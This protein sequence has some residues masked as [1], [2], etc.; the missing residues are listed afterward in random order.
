MT[1]AKGDIMIISYNDYVG[2]G[3]N[4]SDALVKFPHILDTGD[5]PFRE[6]MGEVWEK[7]LTKNHV[8]GKF[9]DNYRKKSN[10]E[11]ADCL[12]LDC[13][14]DSDNEAEWIT[15][16]MLLDNPLL[17]DCAL[18]TS[19]SRNHMKV[20]HAGTDKEKSAR[21]RFHVGLPLSRC[22]VET[23]LK[24]IKK[25]LLYTDQNEKQVRAETA[26]FDKGAK[27]TAHLIYGVPDTEVKTKDGEYVDVVMC[28][29]GLLCLNGKT[30][31]Y[32]AVLSDISYN[33]PS[34]P[35]SPMVSADMTKQ[36]NMPATTSNKASGGDK[37]E[38]HK[39][40]V[41]E[42][43]DMFK[44]IAKVDNLD[45]NDWLHMAMALKSESYDFSLFNELS[46]MI[47]CYVSEEDCRVKWDSVADKPVDD[48][49]T[50]G[51]LVALAQ[52]GGY[53]TWE[54][55]N[56]TD[57]YAIAPLGKDFPP[58][59][60]RL[61][62]GR[63]AALIVRWVG[64]Y[65][66][67]GDGYKRVGSRLLR[68]KTNPKDLG[69]WVIFEPKGFCDADKDPV[70]KLLKSLA[71]RQEAWLEADSMTNPKL[72]QKILNFIDNT[73]QSA[74]GERAIEELVAKDLSCY[75][76]DMDGQT[77]VLNCCGQLVD[78][79][80]NP[81][82]E[83][84]DKQQ[85]YEYN[86]RALQPCDYIMKSTL[87][88]P[89][90]DNLDFVKQMLSEILVKEDGHTPDEDLID[91][92]QR[93]IG[94]AL[95]CN[96]PNRVVYICSA[97]SKDKSEEGNGS[98]GKS[99]LFNAIRK[100]LGDYGVTI[101]QQLLTKTSSDSKRFSTNKLFG[102]R[103]A[104]LNEAPD[105]RLDANSL[106]ILAPSDGE[107]ISA[108]VKNVPR[109][110]FYA[111]HTVFVLT[112][113]EQT[114]RESDSGTWRRIVKIPFNAHFEPSV[115]GNAKTQ[116][117]ASLECAGA[118]LEFAIQGAIWAYKHNYV[119][120]MPHSVQEATR[121]YKLEQNEILTF[122]EDN[123][124]ETCSYETN[125]NGE[126]VGEEG[127]IEWEHEVTYPDNLQAAGGLLNLYCYWAGKHQPDKFMRADF[128]KRLQ[129]CYKP[130]KKV[131]SH[132]MFYI[133][134]I[135]RRTQEAPTFSDKHN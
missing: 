76:K 92:F 112:N 43:Q 127:R 131:R 99:T 5:M 44:S 79:R 40:S 21:P 2:D 89:S 58:F 100:A 26:F 57:E 77:C 109:I 25:A 29:K 32:E 19:T 13:D 66:Q 28:N 74:K 67:E 129:A 87:A 125:K 20:K 123:N 106:K 94:C 75:V 68:L 39:Y 95:L 111:T 104:L 119:I 91:Y 48:G 46:K 101:D 55:L 78:L 83:A 88:K 7:A 14:N 61:N 135:R 15:P 113:N 18:W 124:L 98:N 6:A 121:Q 115:E 41:R 69:R 52:Q 65:K 33:T 133:Y 122:L 126:P 105:G 102:A 90:T 8:C 49:I 53:K 103:F 23:E 50:M 47:P 84:S 12:E 108:D 116:K 70:H 71:L 36:L 17:K 42:L 9:K 64:Q 62:E 16:E 27:D 34:K 22:V 54:S 73:E 31:Q 97:K 56:T 82:Q 24:Q 1:G 4:T 85:T 120:P 117:L 110:E 107:E 114:V 86:S 51:T 60:T 93:I 72:K 45:Y 80:G 10:F 132:N 59:P 130:V 128:L 37:K 3:G 118:W 11:Y 96:N 30:G 63:V 134:G 81:E 35:N 38:Y